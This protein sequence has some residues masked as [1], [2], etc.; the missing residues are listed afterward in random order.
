M[1]PGGEDEEPAPSSPAN[2]ER[3]TLALLRLADEAYR[4]HSCP[5]SAECCQLAARRREPWLW[6]PEWRLVEAKA[7]SLHAGALPPDRTDGGCPFLDAAGLRC[8]VYDARPFGCRTFFCERRTGPV[9]EPAEA[10][11]RLLRRLEHA[12]QRADPDEAGPRPL[13]EW[14]QRAR[15]SG[16]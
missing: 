7:R 14:I 16:D 9:K 13:R 6:S 5:A 10:V 12:A 4:G 3:E 1:R 2:A 11:T 8:T 15:G